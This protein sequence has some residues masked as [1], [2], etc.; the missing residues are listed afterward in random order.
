MQIIKAARPIS[1]GVKQQSPMSLCRLL[2]E[3]NKHN[4]HYILLDSATYKRV[5]CLEVYQFCYFAHL[6]RTSAPIHSLCPSLFLFLI[7][8]SN[9]STKPLLLSRRRK[10]RSRYLLLLLVFWS[11]ILSRTWPQPNIY[12]F[13]KKI[14]TTH[15]NERFA[16]FCTRDEKHFFVSRQAEKKRFS[17]FSWSAVWEQ[18]ENVLLESYVST[19]CL[20]K[21]KVVPCCPVVFNLPLNHTTKTF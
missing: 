17:V 2:L 14:N 5:N 12:L 20:T 18:I 16:S 3:N 13:I 6:R 8:F 15:E 21:K 19:F 9:Q 4:G 7:T 11:L 1:L 10:E